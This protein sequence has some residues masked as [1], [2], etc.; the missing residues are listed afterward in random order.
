MKFPAIEWFLCEYQ[1]LLHR[2]DEI[3]PLA[4]GSTRNN[5]DGAVTWLSPFIAH[6]IINTKLVSQRLLVRYS[7]SQCSKLLFEL[8]WREYFH[9]IWQVHD[10]AIFENMRQPVDSSSYVDHFKRPPA[11]LIDAQTGIQIIDECVKHLIAHGTMHNHARLWVASL[12]CN[13]GKTHWLEPARWFHYHLLDGDLASNSLSWQWV[14]GSFS[15]KRYFANQDNINKYSGQTQTDTFLDR[16]YAELADMDVPA[17]FDERAELQ[18]NKGL[19]DSQPKI[20]GQSVA[21]RSLWNLA[22]DWRNEVD[23]QILF[24]DQDHYQQWPMSEKRWRF[25]KHWAGQI[26][27]AS[28]MSG[29]LETLR[30]ACSGKTVRS[31]EYPACNDWFPNPEP[32]EWLYH[33]PQKPFNSFFA[34][35]K[36]VKTDVGLS[37]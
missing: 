35:W 18:L 2:I 21:V 37:A 5:L 26:P 33:C 17:H 6:G 27:N 16:S 12:A 8:A 9:R 25:I 14:Y 20:D 34:F 31:Q 36:Q 10:N 13:I 24:V 7:A 19:P 22:P 28:I 11:A 1:E 30:D 32:R 29:S 4:Y 23:Q 3:D 15:N